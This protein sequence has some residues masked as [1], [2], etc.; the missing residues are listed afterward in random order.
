MNKQT[1]EILCIA[2]EECAEVTQAISKIFRF[3]IDSSWNGRT[4][5]ERLEEELGD[6]LAMASLLQTKE[7]VREQKVL[8]AWH[9]KMEK[10]S[11][12]S[13]IEFNKVDDQDDK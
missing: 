11:I 7:I 1:K 3:G 2:Q 12:W 5:Q 13:N 10:L 4:N 9:N 8:E 6:L